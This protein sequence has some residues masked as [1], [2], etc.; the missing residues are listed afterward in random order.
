MTLN[1]VDRSIL[2]LCAL[3]E[4]NQELEELEVPGESGCLPGLHQ[5]TS[6]LYSQFLKTHS[7]LSASPKP[8]TADM[9]VAIRAHLCYFKPTSDS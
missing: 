2:A 5:T 4:V 7:T 9:K 6:E 1:L 3:Q 8:S